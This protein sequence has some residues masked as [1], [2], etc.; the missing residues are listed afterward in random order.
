MALTREIIETSS[1]HLDEVAKVLIISLIRELDI[2][3]AYATIFSSKLLPAIVAA[4]GT[5][6][7]RKLNGL[8]KEIEKLGL[9]NIEINDPKEGL[10]YSQWKERQDLIYQ[11]LNTLLDVSVLIGAGTGNEIVKTK[12]IYG[13][14]AVKQRPCY[15]S[16]P[17]ACK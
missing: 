10:K 11:M 6:N 8:L 17:C 15:H 13:V 3:K 2:Y 4:E 12:G 5:L 7:A 9:G 14:A 1:N 16:S